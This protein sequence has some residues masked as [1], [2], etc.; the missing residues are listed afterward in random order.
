MHNAYQGA[1]FTAL[2]FHLEGWKQISAMK[3]YVSFTPL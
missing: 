3:K 2:V 1:L